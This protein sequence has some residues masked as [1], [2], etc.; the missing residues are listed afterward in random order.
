MYKQTNSSTVL[1]RVEISAPPAI[2]VQIGSNKIFVLI[3]RQRQLVYKIDCFFIYLASP[4][5][6]VIEFACW[7]AQFFSK[8]REKVRLSCQ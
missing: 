8:V 6:D 5:H 1:K 3:N 4:E 2:C 7:I